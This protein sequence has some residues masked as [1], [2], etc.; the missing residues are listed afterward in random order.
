MHMAS[1]NYSDYL[2]EFGRN[3]M[4]QQACLIVMHPFKMQ[5]LQDEV[6]A[7]L[8]GYESDESDE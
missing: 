6:E 3:E 7:E 5:A 4:V 1:Q 2:S 8:E